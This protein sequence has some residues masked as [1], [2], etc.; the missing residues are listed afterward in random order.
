MDELGHGVRAPQ[1]GSAMGERALWINREG[2][3]VQ[4]LPPAPHEC[5]AEPEPWSPLGFNLLPPR[6]A[7]RTV[8]FKEDHYMLRQS[9]MAS[10]H[11]DTPM[12]RS[13][14]LKGR[15]TVCWK[16]NNNV[17]KPGFS[18]HAAANPKE[19]SEC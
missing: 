5:K 8:G 15:D 6:P 2:L 13:G 17:H 19:L 11:L 14:S 16:I 3:S 1:Q 7:G 9:L 18:S 12:V 10:D 4:L